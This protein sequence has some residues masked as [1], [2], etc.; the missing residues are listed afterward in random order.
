ME[1]YSPGLELLGI[2]ETCS[3]VSWES[4]AFS[5]G[6]FTLAAPV[7]GQTRALL[8][9]DNI[10]WFDEHAAGIIE[11]IEQEEREEGPSITVKGRELSGILDR[12]ILW[13][14]YALHGSVPDI[15]RQLVADC[16][17]TPTRG[18]A[19]TRKVPGLVLEEQS[20]TGTAIHMQ[21]TGGTLLEA[22]KSL[23][24]AYDVA[25]GVRFDPAVPQMVFW[26]RSGVDRSIHQS[27]V[28]PVFY[29][30]ELDDVLSSEYTYNSAD[31]RNVALV[32]GEGEGGQRAA[33]TVDESVLSGLAR[34][35]L[36]VDARDLQSDADP[37][38]SLTPEE[39]TDLLSS[40]G[41]EKIAENSLVRS[42]SA[43]IRTVSPTYIYGTDFQLGD[44]ITV[45]DERLGVSADA[46]VEA[47]EQSVGEN[48]HE[49]TLTLG[50]GQPT[51]HDILRRKAGK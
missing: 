41:R 7:T 47:V 31:Y 5:A 4:R 48:G 21:T 17:I 20:G 32:L 10:I 23:G 18:D 29:S 44:T 40:R 16:C 11:Y 6:S 19:E 33:V 30:T 26:A 3:S 2:L 42:F 34:R 50:Y 43:D 28:E 39:Y 27:A 9:P 49:L 25:F 8:V 1:V 12:R 38:N 36:Y 37:D 22:L 45:T 35:E 24:T 51:L 14:Q 15:M 13:G 46:I